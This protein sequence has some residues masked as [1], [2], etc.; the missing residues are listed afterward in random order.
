MNKLVLKPKHKHF[1]INTFCLMIGI[2]AA[3]LL[4]QWVLHEFSYDRFI[5]D[6]DRIYRLVSVDKATGTRY[7]G[8]VC[9]LRYDLPDAV[10]QVE[11]CVSVVSHYTNL[12]PNTVR[13]MERNESFEVMALTTSDNFFNV[14]TYPVVEG[15]PHHILK[16]NEAA[17]SK[18]MAQKLYDGSAIGQP[19]VCSYMHKETVYTVALV[20]DVPTNTHLPFE[21]VMPMDSRQLNLY[22]NITENQTI[23]VKLRENAL[24]SKAE[25]KRL[26][27]I[28]TE[29]YDKQQWLEF[30]PLRDIHLHTDY[31]DPESVGNGNASYVWI[32]IFGILLIVAV[33]IVN[34]ATLDVSYSVQQTK[35]RVVKR[36]FGC[37]EFRIFSSNLLETL[38]ITLVA[39]GLSLLA[40]WALLPAFQSWIGVPVQLRFDKWLLFFCLALLVLLP[41][42]SSLFGQY[43][44]RSVAFADVLKGKMRHLKGIRISNA[45]SVF[46]V[47]L[48]SLA[49]VFTIVILLQLTFMRHSDKGVDMSNIV[50]LNSLVTPCYK[51]GPIRDELMKNPDI[52][53]VG[54]CMGDFS[55]PNGF[56]R[57]VDWEGR[58]EGNDA[59]FQVLYTDGYFQEMVGMELLA[60]DYLSK[61]L[62]LDDYFEGKYEGNGQYVV[63]EAAVK[64]MGWS[65]EDAIG[66]DLTLTVTSGRIVG[67]VKDFHFSDMRNA[68]SPL[69]MEYAPEAQ[70]NIVVK[71]APENRQQTLA[72]IQEVVRPFNF[73][74]VISCS[75]LGEK[76]LY[77][78]ERQVGHLSLLYFLA[79]MLLALFGFFG[80]VS[81]HL[82]QEETN[83]A[84]RK[85]YGATNREVMGH[86]LKTKLRLYVLPILVATVVSVYFSLNWLQNFAYHLSVPLVLTVALVSVFAAFLLLSL[87]TSG[88]VQAVCSR[89]ITDVLQK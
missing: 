19:L 87:I 44:L 4:F 75:F 22:R 12:N 17:I 59:V 65:V 77:R 35:N 29:K 25:M 85:V 6:S 72:Y 81:Y 60:G 32:I 26:A 3:T 20:V 42:A 45:S 41:L 15:E 82:H 55:K 13:D 88:V 24:F 16:P 74:D 1:L 38:L 78:E 83:M 86:Y 69:I 56:I 48:S 79:A 40:V 58:E 66:K 10:P 27:N 9:Q 7:T 11:E 23:Y 30:Q 28:Q 47:G 14:F 39:M 70:P 52:Y 54:L 31:N 71:I 61:D 2:T 76:E 43:C 84:V 62:N 53:S 50:S 8:G 18:E 73:T 63:N 51:V 68:V 80:V 89:K 37:S 64:A 67:V 49:A 36:V 5:E 21:V 46:Q 33:T 34:C 57:D